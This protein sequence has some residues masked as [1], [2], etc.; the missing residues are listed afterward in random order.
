MKLIT[1]TI[2][3]LEFITEEKECEDY[4]IQYLSARDIKNRNEEF[5]LLMYY[6][7]KLTDTTKNL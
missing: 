4:K 6:T 5:I 3:N 2:E 7:K 1:E